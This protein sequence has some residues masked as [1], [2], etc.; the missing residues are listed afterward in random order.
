MVAP[1]FRFGYVKK[2]S[3]WRRK[4]WKYEGISSTIPSSSVDSDKV[5]QTSP[6]K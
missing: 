5:L 2:F 3:W 4:W 1:D 6:V